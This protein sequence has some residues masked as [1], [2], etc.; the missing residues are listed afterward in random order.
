[1]K[2]LIVCLS[3]LV[4]TVFTL[5]SS[6]VSRDGI[7]GGSFEN[8]R[9]S[10]SITRYTGGATTS[11]GIIQGVNARNGSYYGYL[12]DVNSTTFSADGALYQ[13]ILPKPEDSADRIE[14]SYYLNVTSAEGTSLEYD[15][16]DVML[17]FLD[18]NGD[19]AHE[20]PLAHYSNKNKDQNNDSRNYSLKS[21]SLVLGDL[22]AAASCYLM[23]KVKTDNNLYTTFR[24]DDV[25]LKVVRNVYTVNASAGSGGNISPAGSLSAEGY[26]SLSFTATANSDYEIDK[27]FVNNS[28][29]QTGGNTYTLSRVTANKTVNVA[30]KPKLYE[31]TINVNGNGSYTIDPSDVGGGIVPAAGNSYMFPAGTRVTLKANPASGHRFLEWKSDDSDLYSVS[32]DYT[33]SIT[34]HSTAMTLLFRRQPVELV[35][36][37][38]PTRPEIVQAPATQVGYIQVMESSK[39]GTGWAPLTAKEFTGDT[40]ERIDLKEQSIR[41]PNSSEMFRWAFYDK[42]SIQPFLSFPLAPGI[43]LVDAKVSAIMDHGKRFAGENAVD[44]FI[45]TLNGDIF[46]VLKAGEE[47][48]HAIEGTVRISDGGLSIILPTVQSVLN[49]P[50]DYVG[51][52]KAGPS[53]LQY[54]GHDGYDYPYGIGTIIYA[55]ASGKTVGP[56]DLSKFESYQGEKFTTLPSDNMREFHGLII[57][58]NNGYYTRYLHLS[59]IESAFVDK[60][61]AN[62]WKPKSGVSVTKGAIIGKVGDKGAEKPHLHFSVWRTDNNSKMLRVVDPYGKFAQDEKVIEPNLWLN[63]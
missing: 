29:V 31:L 41:N 1:M 60:T 36:F 17:R 35:S 10:W 44:K 26:S 56:D 21:H 49:L 16:L 63:P 53:A 4:L 15:K 27:W 24:I 18:Y 39:D 37:P 50:F 58:H 38:E 52:V 12:G 11:A 22:V 33:F 45:L 61:D 6:E 19:L 2:K 7:L 5:K 25:V 9:S 40:A 30:F 51:T 55:P 62:N 13:Y 43:K 23:F 54:D 59:D 20:E 28:R 34:A 47:F 14:V 46:P 57:D 42:L 32:Q 3:M 48:I 8:N